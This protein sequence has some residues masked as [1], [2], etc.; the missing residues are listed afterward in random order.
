MF[1]D[2]VHHKQIQHH[3]DEFKH[4]LDLLIILLVGNILIVG[5]AVLIRPSL[6]IEDILLRHLGEFQHVLC[7]DILGCDHK[8]QGHLADGIIIIL[9]LIRLDLTLVRND[10]RGG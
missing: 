1:F 2:E 7:L 3:K 10:D 4:I 9:R 5:Q 6:G 8:L